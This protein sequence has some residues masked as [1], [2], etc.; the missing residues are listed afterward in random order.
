MRSGFGAGTKDFRDRA[1]A[2]RIILAD[3][4]AR[5][6]AVATRES[7]VELVCDIDDMSPEYLAPSSNALRDA[8]ALDVMLLAETMKHGRPAMRV[9]VLC[10]PGDGVAPRGAAAR[11]DDDDRRAAARGRATGACRAT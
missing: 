10:R 3:D 6:G 1:N 11:R 9:E 4:D 2:L 8:G 7:L 5:R